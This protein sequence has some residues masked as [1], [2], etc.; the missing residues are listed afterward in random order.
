MYKTFK[1]HSRKNLEMHVETSFCLPVDETLHT[2]TITSHSLSWSSDNTYHTTIGKGGEGERGRG[3][4]GERGRGGEGERGRG[5]EG[6]RGRG[7]EGERGRGGEGERGRGGEGERGRGGE[8]ELWG[9][10]GHCWTAV[11]VVDV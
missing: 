6:E 8:G 11:N 10:A 7:G 1:M 5:G 9:M 3:G 4:E 2:F